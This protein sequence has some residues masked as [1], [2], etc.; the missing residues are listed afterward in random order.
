MKYFIHLIF[1]L[2]TPS[3]FAQNYVPNGSFEEYEK[4]PTA[5]QQFKGY[6]RNWHSFTAGTP[7]Y[8]NACSS[9]AASGVP[10]NYNGDQPAFAGKA[11]AGLYVYPPTGTPSQ[12]TSE[13]LATR[14]TPLMKGNE[15]EVSMYVSLADRS[16]W[17][18]DG[19]GVFF[20]TDSGYVNTTK[21]LTFKPHVSFTSFGV[22]NDDNAW[23]RISGKFIADSAY[24]YMVIGQFADTPTIVNSPDNSS[25]PRNLPYAYYYIDSASV[26]EIINHIDQD[27]LR[28]SKCKPILH[29]RSGKEYCVGMSFIFEFIIE[30]SS[31][32]SAENEYHPEFIRSDGKLFPMPIQKGGASGIMKWQIPD[33][34]A[35]GVYHLRIVT[36]DPVDSTDYYQPIIIYTYPVIQATSNKPQCGGEL[37]LEA[38]T[39]GTDMVVWQG[40]AAFQG[41]GLTHLIS[42]MSNANAGVYIA[43]A[44]VYCRSS[45]TVDVQLNCDSLYLPTA[46]SPNGDGKNDV[47]YIYGTKEVSQLHLSIYDKWGQL[48]FETTDVNAGW[49]GI[50]QDEN[51]DIAVFAY[52][53]DAVFKSGKKLHA[54]GNITEIK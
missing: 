26:T 36:T 45:D 35:A 25:K 28:R 54:K 1:A 13:Y 47:L 11:Y 3:A 30:D 40:P 2:I 53:L 18:C 20:K 41:E 31:L 17:A 14:I 49:N 27:S 42:N 52:V 6:C 8:F 48:V 19:L 16:Q 24:A 9:P 10:T 50:Y 15:Y 32:V 43:S 29:L 7:D 34:M 33:T 4:C 23:V 37:R 44:G 12:R 39:T 38:T 46:F 51:T 21:R 22:L 5:L